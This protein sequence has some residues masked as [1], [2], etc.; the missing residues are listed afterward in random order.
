M[1]DKTPLNEDIAMDINADADIPGN[2]HL[3]NSVTENSGDIEKLQD[4]LKEQKDKYLR[5]VA[6]FENFKRR[7]AKERVEL[8]QT[9]GKEIIISLLDILDDAERA[10]KQMQSNSEVGQIKEGITLVFNKLRTTLHQKGLVPMESIQTN[11]D[12]EKHEAIAE[13]D[14]GEKMKGKV[15]DEVQK[16]YYLNDKILRF[17]KVVVG[18]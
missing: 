10:E 7:T 9:A 2:T 12:V 14:L 6:E 5:L 3:S 17:A 4:E 16:G 1:E 8:S 13:V 18:K 11:F 15:A